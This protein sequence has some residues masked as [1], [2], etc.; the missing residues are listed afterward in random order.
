MDRVAGL[1]SRDPPVGLVYI[2]GDAAYNDGDGTGVL[3]VTGDMTMNG[4]FTYRGL[5]YV[6]GNL[7]L[8][9]QAWILGGLIV[10]GMTEIKLANGTASVFYS[11]DM[12]SEAASSSDGSFQRLSWREL[13]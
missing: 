10:N 6:E 2:D 4:H 12:I 7:H 11:S 3:Y 9:G 8:N 1:T 5:I 13:P